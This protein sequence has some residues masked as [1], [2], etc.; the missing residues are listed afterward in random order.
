MCNL[1]IH[2]YVLSNKFDTTGPYT[3]VSLAGN[4]IHC[5]CNTEKVLKVRPPKLC[6]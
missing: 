6:I 1:Q 2:T 4:Y 5:D 3:T